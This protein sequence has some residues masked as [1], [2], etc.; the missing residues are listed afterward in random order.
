MMSDCIFCRIVEGG[1]PSTKLYEDNDCLAFEDLNPQAPVHGLVIPK[2]HLRALSDAQEHDQALL[3]S[4]M[5]ACAHVAKK[6][7]LESNGYRV[8]TNI[9]REA[10]Q[11]VFHLHFHVLGGRSFQWPPG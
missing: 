1:I 4:L 8:V 3:G 2:K 10:G 11:T 5:L 6:K 7:E 9:G